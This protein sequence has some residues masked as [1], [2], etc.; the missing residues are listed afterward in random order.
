M[1]AGAVWLGVG[2]FLAAMPG[3]AEQRARLDQP[4][5]DSLY[6]VLGDNTEDPRSRWAELYGKTT[7]EVHTLLG[8]P[9]TVS[10][11]EL[12]GVR[13]LRIS[14]ECEGCPAGASAEAQAACADG[15]RYGPH[16]YFR[17]G[18]AVSAQQFL[19][20]TGA[21]AYPAEPEHLKFKT[22]SAFP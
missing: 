18:T 19:N 2:V 14:Y 1:R 3:H 5:C 7:H 8:D 6:E 4:R 10:I 20:E 21:I 17:N 12:Q 11:L 22:S 9:T 15:W 13:W 16:V